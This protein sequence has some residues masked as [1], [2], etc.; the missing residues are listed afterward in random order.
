MS[1]SKVTSAL[2]DANHTVQPLWI[3]ISYGVILF[4]FIH[5]EELNEKAACGGAARRLQKL[6]MF[7]E[8]L[9]HPQPA[10]SQFSSRHD[11]I[12]LCEWRESWW[13]VSLTREKKTRTMLQ[14]MC[15]CRAHPVNQMYEFSVTRCHYGS[16]V[17]FWRS[18]RWTL[19]FVAWFH[20]D[21]FNETCFVKA[22]DCIV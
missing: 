3:Y 9:R 19:F 18:S 1:I 17:N 4:S 11:R 15:S 20:E 5:R 14:I 6:D 7:A 16:H 8:I 12:L 22:T 13:G 21:P 2:K 10:Q